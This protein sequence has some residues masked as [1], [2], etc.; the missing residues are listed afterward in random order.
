MLILGLNVFHADSA[1]VLLD[2]DR[3]IA[4]VAEERL[5]RVKHFSGFP[6]AAI[7]EVLRQGGAEIGAVD[8]FAVG[9]DSKANLAAKALFVA[10]RLGRARSLVG[11]RLKNRTKV[12]SVP[13]LLEREFG[14]PWRKAAARL[15]QVEH[16]LAHA[17]SAFYVSPFERAAVA[18]FDGF[19]DF[20][21][22]LLAEGRGDSL[23]LL[24]RTLFPHSLGILYTAFCAFIGFDRYGDEGKVMGLAP[25]GEDA[26]ADF[27]DELVRLKP[28]GRYE[29]NLDYF[30]HHVE[31]VDYVADEDGRPYVAPLYSQ[32]LVRKLGP[33]RRRG[34][35][36]TRRD[37]NLARSLQGCLER[38]YFH[39]LNHLHEVVGTDCLCLAGGVALN[40]VANGK[41]FDHTPFKRLY[42]QPAA[43]DDGTALGA[44][45]QTRHGILGKPRREVV[46]SALLGPE[47]SAAECRRALD[48]AGA[49][50]EKLTEDELVRRAAAEVAAGKIVGWF[51]GRM[52]WGP[53]ALGARSIVAHPGLPNMKDIL[54]ARIKHREPFRPFAPSVLE[55]R[56]GE[57]FE[58][59]HPNPFM[60]TVYGI[61][62]EW[63]QRLRAVNHVD[64][65]GRLQTVSRKTN[66]LY[67]RLI[68][69]F[70][71][72]TG[73]PAVLNTSF[74][75]NEPI[76]CRPE[77]AVD[78][79]FRTK[80]D[81]LAL[82]PY[83]VSRADGNAG[84][85]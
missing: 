40:S 79:F 47:F 38:A 19:G 76:V 24:D 31:G 64:H 30:T 35:V 53:R 42:I 65:T 34:G 45:L 2:D 5:N 44:A 13:R 60:L 4:A 6:V 3:L 10:R 66:P 67:H 49:A 71:E 61:R 11:Q 17:A 7:R 69:E 82:G 22:G 41:V 75:E 48:K 58:H 26:Y 18:T 14:L 78:C 74:N 46:D 73:L 36:L 80:M 28:R 72:L 62:P 52:E 81:A 8:R 83:Y 16:H 59:D 20:A 50:A 63:R 9:R 27:F 56:T 70:E 23:K 77:E 37:K 25:Y 21:S 57:L 43:G 29:L 39:V 55:E 15:V 84:S 68:E 1:A 51:Q 54:N 33:P 85:P 32:K 12:A